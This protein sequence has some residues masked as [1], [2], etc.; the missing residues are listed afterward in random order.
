MGYKIVYVCYMNHDMQK[1]YAFISEGNSKVIIRDKV[2]EKNGIIN[3]NI[4]M[5][6]ITVEFF[7][8]LEAAIK[9]A[10]TYC[11]YECTWGGIYLQNP[12]SKKWEALSAP[13]ETA[14]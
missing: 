3:K 6:L 12:E 8:T 1:Q 7:D 5:P 2:T 11:P 9:D 4:M 14:K 13:A 10:K